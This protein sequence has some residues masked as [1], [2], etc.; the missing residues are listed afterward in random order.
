MSY[1]N[2]I[3]I[4]FIPWDSVACV[5]NLTF[6]AKLIASAVIPIGVLALI[7]LFL[8]VPLKIRDRRDYKDDNTAR[9]IRDQWRGKSYRLLL[10]TLFLLYPATSARILSMFVCRSIDGKSYL[11]ADFTIE[12]GGQDWNQYLPFAIVFLF[13][14]PI[15]IPVFYFLLLRRYRDKADSSPKIYLALGFL[16]NAYTK[17]KWWFELAD[18]IHKLLLTSILPFFPISSQLP[19]G[20]AIIII[21][22]CGILLLCPYVRIIDDRLHMLSQIELFLL[23]LMGSVVNVAG[24]IQEGSAIDISLS[25]LMFMLTFALICFFLYHCLLLFRRIV[26]NKQ[27]LVAVAIEAEEELVMVTATK[28]PL[29]GSVD[30]DNPILVRHGSETELP[31]SP[32]MMSPNERTRNRPESP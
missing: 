25:T 14:Y 31:S 10:W 18:M 5:T 7:S 15:G 6:F 22:L 3:S 19:F 2:F 23:L 11:M 20:M 28:N 32:S 30:D 16:F 24:N 17:Q 29:R 4:D 13:L 12:C 8:L 9:N 27:R 26:R 1:M 21:Y